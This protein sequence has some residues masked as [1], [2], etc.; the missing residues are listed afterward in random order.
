M[1]NVIGARQLEQLQIGASL[2]VPADAIITPLAMDIIREKRLKLK[3]IEAEADVASRTRSLELDEAEAALNEVERPVSSNVQE[4]GLAQTPPSRDVEES[5]VKAIVGTTVKHVLSETLLDDV[6]TADA[7]K[8]AVFGPDCAALLRSVAQE[9]ERCSGRLVRVSG[10]TVA[11]LFVLA[12]AVAVP[13][14]RR[15]EVK[16]ALETGFSKL[17][18]PALFE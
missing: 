12:V 13:A 7:V 1:T 18:V 3:R 2:H 16:N 5:E 14:A 9:V 4:T 8:F 15:D 6:G 17:T 11:G 10:R